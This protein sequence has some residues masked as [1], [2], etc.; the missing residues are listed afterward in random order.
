MFS[1]LARTQNSDRIRYHMS[2][3]TPSQANVFAA[4]AIP[5]ERRVAGFW[6]RLFAFLVDGVIVGVGAALVAAPFFGPL[7]RV[8]AWG[9][10]IGF[11][12]AL[13]YF[14]FLNSRFGGGRTLGKRWLKIQVVDENGQPISFR[15]S[16]IRYTV[17]AIPFS[18]NQLPL[19]VTRT[20][21]FVFVGITI[22][23]IL[24]GVSVYLVICNRRTRQ[25]LHDLAVKSYVASVA[26]SGAIRRQTIWPGHWAILVGLGVAA[27]TGV[28]VL[29]KKISRAYP[30]GR[31][32]DDLRDIEGMAGVQSAGVQ[33]L[34]WHSWSGGETKTI[35][36]VIVRWDGASQTDED[37]AKRVARLL[38]QNDANVAQRDV[39]RIVVVRGFDLGIANASVTHPFEHTP[40]EWKQIVLPGANQKDVSN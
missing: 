29:E 37:G 39:L 13:P 31:M 23:L 2:T 9:R 17:F 18:L 25:G 3:I 38:L 35:F 34:T 6:R 26:E 36:V 27:W 8:G 5:R 33:D 11:C 15:R 22:M 32:L 20:P 30:M 16:L 7:S 21:S 1:S 10:L 14:A 12:M 19:P 40:A 4:L 28:H 24:G